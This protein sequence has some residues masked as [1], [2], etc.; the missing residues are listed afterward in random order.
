MKLAVFD[1]VPLAQLPTPLE[2]LDH[3]TREAGGPRL[4]IKRDDMTGL[5]L[6]GNKTRKLEFAMGAALAVGADTVITAGGFQSNHARQ[7]AAAAAKLGLSCELVLTQNAPPDDDDYH[8]SGNMLLDRLLG[9][10]LHLH[11]AGSDREKLMNER[12]DALRG[13]GRHPFVIP[14]GASYPIGNLGYAKAALEIV[15]QADMLDIA[16]DY[17]VL[18]TS[19]GGTLAGLAAGFDTLGYPLTLIG[20]DIDDND[21]CL[22]DIIMPQVSAT[23]ELMGYGPNLNH[24]RIEI[25]FGHAGEGYGFHTADMVEAV[26]KAARRE[27]LLL[28][29]VYSG[30]AMAGLLGLLRAG[31]FQEN[32]NVL[33]LH[34]GGAAGLFGYRSYLM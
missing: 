25:L 6:G 18:P 33:F 32:E 26:E 20:V 3:L 10:R 19:S 9:A 29:P 7:T 11:P 24:C 34:T 13:E 12:A 27:G 15:A 22:D 2:R 5:A 1:R 4:F 30:K 17:L 31:R 21:R 16:F 8:K 28:D 23:R 14:L